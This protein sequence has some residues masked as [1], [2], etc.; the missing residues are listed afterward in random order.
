[1]NY[2]PPKTAC[3]IWSSWWR[4]HDVRNTY[5]RHQEL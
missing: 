1:M 5:R 2:I 4:T 3:T